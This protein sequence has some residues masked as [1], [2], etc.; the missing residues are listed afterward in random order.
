MI[1]VNGLFFI[2]QFRYCGKL[3]P[4]SVDFSFRKKVIDNFLFAYFKWPLQV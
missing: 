1:K 2:N 3:F 4:N